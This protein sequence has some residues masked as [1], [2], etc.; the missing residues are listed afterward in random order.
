MQ[1]WSM[2]LKREQREAEQWLQ[3]M[4]Q[5]PSEEVLEVGTLIWREIVIKVYK[6]LEAW[7]VLRAE[8]LAQS[9]CTSA[10]GTQKLTGDGCETAKF[11][12]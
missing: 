12:L 7:N 3:G 2:C 10:K 8:L 11:C 5:M 1:L 6:I 9:C 4:E